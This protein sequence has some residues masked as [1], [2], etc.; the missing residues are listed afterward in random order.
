MVR[1]SSAPESIVLMMSSSGRGI[2]DRSGLSIVQFNDILLLW[3]VTIVSRWGMDYVG[4]ESWRRKVGYVSRYKM[5]T[6]LVTNT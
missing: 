6:A 4:Y 2:G 5:R 3:L 1:E